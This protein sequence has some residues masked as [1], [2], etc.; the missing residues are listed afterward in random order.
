M[1][2]W[3]RKSETSSRMIYD[4][5]KSK[6]RIIDNQQLSILR[7]EVKVQRLSHMGVGIKRF[8]NGENPYIRI[9]I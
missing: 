2:I 9:K 1:P 8:R 3:R 7:K 4:D 5:S 6:D